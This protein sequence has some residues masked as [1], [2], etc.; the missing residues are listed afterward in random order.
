[1][2]SIQFKQ[3]YPIK[4]LAFDTNNLLMFLVR[5]E[6]SPLGISSEAVFQV[7]LAQTIRLKKSNSNLK[8]KDVVVVA[9]QMRSQQNVEMA[10]SASQEQ[11]FSPL[12]QSGVSNF[13][14]G[15]RK[16]NKKMPSISTNQHSVVLPSML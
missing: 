13:A 2:I 16:I 1:M 4:F 12:D 9:A 15:E 10:C 14:L 11:V 5:N 6:C 3:T 7:V 8:Q